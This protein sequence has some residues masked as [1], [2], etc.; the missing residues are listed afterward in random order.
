MKEGT[1]LVPEVRLRGGNTCLMSQPP[2]AFSPPGV[3]KVETFFA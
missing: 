2:F 3:E 1:Q